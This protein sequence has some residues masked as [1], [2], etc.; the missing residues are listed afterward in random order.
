MKTIVISA[1]YILPFI[2]RFRPVFAHYDLELILPTV[3]ERLS[4]TELLQLA[5]KF[6][7]I[8]CGD[9]RFTEKVIQQCAP[10][11][12]V[13]AKWGTGIDSI[14]KA[15]A[16]R[17]GVKIRNTVNAFTMPVADTVM[18]YMLAFA[19]NIPWMDNYMKAGK[20]EKVAGASLFECTLG[21]IGLGNVGKAVIR[22]A[23]AFG[24]ELLGN[25]IVP[26]A[27][28]FVAENGVEMTG[29]SDLLRRSD[30][31]SLNCDLNSTSYH[32]INAKTLAEM[33]PTAVLINTARGPIIDEPALVNSLQ[34]GLAS[35]KKHGKTMEGIH[36]VGLDVFEVEPLP[37]DSPLLK[38]ENALLAPHNSNS[39]PQSWERV[40][41]NTIRGLLEGMDIP[42]DDL[43]RIFP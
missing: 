9:D 33:K 31:I 23:R 16:E 25:D 36:G 26:I 17:H 30:F 19:R 15:A 27:P 6:D 7:G 42:C 18:G 41:R 8:I 10:R 3:H 40:H 21:V 2:D 43:D 12:K 22:R 32:L 38:L 13:I 5:G 11:L 29:L 14:H 24:M 34:K 20:W 37:L 4:E 39:S 1:P 35:F 28:D